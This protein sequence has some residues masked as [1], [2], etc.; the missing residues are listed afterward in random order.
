MDGVL[1]EYLMKSMRVGLLL[2]VIGCLSLLCGCSRTT[3]QTVKPIVS[4]CTADINGDGVE[5]F[6]TIE[7]EDTSQCLESGEAYG[8]TLCIYKDEAGRELLYSFDLSDIKPLMVQAGDVNRDGKKEISVVVYKKTKFHP[9]DAKRPFFYALTDGTLEKVWLGS[10]L[11]RPF[12][13]FVL[14]DLD[15]D[16]FEEIVA[17]ERTGDGKPV[18]ALYKW[19]GFGFDMMAESSPL[20]EE[21]VF[22]EDRTHAL[23]Q[24]R[25]QCNSGIYEVK[26]NGEALELKREE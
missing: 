23:K 19:E 9:V 11:S 26:N 2:G 22:A 10:R 13:D 12:E 3:E 21:A 8:N 1:G 4:F 16:G 20:S 25:I 17:I 6:L 18:I 15:E 7:T 14:Y 5:E 24:V